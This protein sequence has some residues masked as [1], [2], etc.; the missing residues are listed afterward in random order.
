MIRDEREPI[1]LDL[2]AGKDVL[3]VGCVDHVATRAGSDE[4][5]HK[6]LYGRAKSVLGLDYADAEVKK[7][8]GTYN[9]VAGDAQT[10]DL[11]RQFDCVVAG[12]LIEHLDNPGMFLRNML[13]HLRPGGQ[14]VLTT[15]N[16]FY[17]KRLLEVLA[18]GRT[19]INTEHTCW[20]CDVTLTQ[21]LQRVGFCGVRTYF[22]SN[23]LALFA[24]G[25]L[26]RLIRRR[27]SDHIL[28]VAQK[29]T[30]AAR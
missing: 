6:K 5:L 14:I 19:D 20:Y 30:V 22:V 13:K 3:D 24:I 7:L 25:R 9:I 26:P 4:W 29:P 17:P 16:P 23:S 27:F 1:I 18:S 15:P 28:V 11:Q 8:A 2:V 21:L 12:E 10:V